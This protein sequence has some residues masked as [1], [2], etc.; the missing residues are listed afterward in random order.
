MKALNDFKAFILRGNVVD[1]AVGIIIGTA[2]GTVVVA[3]VKDL[4]MPIIAAFGGKPDFTALY[5]T[6][7]HSRFLIGDFLTVLV[8]FLIVAAVVFF[9]VVRPLNQLLARSKQE[10]PPDTSIRNCPFC[11]NSI[12]AQASRCGFCTSEVAPVPVAAVSQA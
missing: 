9:F 5:F 2:F 8:S 7:N 1:L 12:P 10:P 6:I 11:L 4:I 3:L